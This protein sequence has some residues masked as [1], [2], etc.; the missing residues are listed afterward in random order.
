[1]NFVKLFNWGDD[2]L[3][4]DDRERWSNVCKLLPSNG[5]G[6]HKGCGNFYQECKIRVFLRVKCMNIIEKLRIPNCPQLAHKLL[7]ELSILGLEPRVRP[8]RGST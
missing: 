3:V 1:L 6:F 7:K 5:I 4:P 2:F 8:I